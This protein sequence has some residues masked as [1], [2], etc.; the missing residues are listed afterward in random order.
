MRSG[1]H[2]GEGEGHPGNRDRE[3]SGQ[4][5]LGEHLGEGEGQGHAGNRDREQRGQVRS[6]EHLG[7]GEGHT[8]TTDRGTERHR[9]VTGMPGE[10]GQGTQASTGQPSRGT[11]GV[12]SLCIL[13]EAF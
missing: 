9:E 7:E 4:V 6:G 11:P 3:Q 8:G 5:R 2:P 13:P 1:E 10:R 12:L